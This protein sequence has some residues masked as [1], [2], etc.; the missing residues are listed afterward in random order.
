MERNL[1]RIGGVNIH[2]HQPDPVWVKH[3]VLGLPGQQGWDLTHLPCPD[4]FCLECGGHARLVG[5][6]EGKKLGTQADASGCTYL[7]IIFLA[8]SYIPH[9]AHRHWSKRSCSGA[10]A[11]QLAIFSGSDGSEPG[12]YGLDFQPHEGK[13]LFWHNGRN[14]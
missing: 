11:I 6:V 4:W 9:A 12:L 1:A 7:C 13:S 2:G 5:V 3:Q 8:G 10:A 14:N